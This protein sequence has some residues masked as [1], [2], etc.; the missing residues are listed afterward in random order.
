MRGAWKFINLPIFYAIFLV[1]STKT[2]QY[3]LQI[4]ALHFQGGGGETSSDFSDFILLL[5]I[6]LI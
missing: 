3:G 6:L 1:K 2:N 5:L 4:K